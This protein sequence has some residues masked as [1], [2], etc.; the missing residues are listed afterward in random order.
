[1]LPITPAPKLRPNPRLAYHLPPLTHP[2]PSTHTKALHACILLRPSS[3]RAPPS[4]QKQQHA[5]HPHTLPPTILRTYPTTVHTPD[6]HGL[7]ALR[8]TTPRLRNLV[9]LP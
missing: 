1:L 7:P 4:Q 3:A 9:E 5:A 6:E 8:H 2:P